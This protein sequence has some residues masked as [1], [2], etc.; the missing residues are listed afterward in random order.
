[1]WLGIVDKITF[2]DLF[3]IVFQTV[4]TASK[5]IVLEV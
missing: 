3:D 1:M 4:V 2:F 5:S